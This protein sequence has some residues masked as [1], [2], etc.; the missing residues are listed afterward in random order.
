[1]SEDNQKRVGETGVTSVSNLTEADLKEEQASKCDANHFVEDD[2][3][4]RNE[5]K[6]F[7]MCILCKKMMRKKS[8]HELCS[9][10]QN[11]GIVTLIKEGKIKIEDI[12]K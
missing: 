7:F 3:M 6:N 4:V 10:C 5:N 2:V 11:A 8:K 12:K 9:H 1:M